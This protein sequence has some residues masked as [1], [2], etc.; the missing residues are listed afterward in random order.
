[1]K[2]KSFAVLG[3]GKYGSSLAAGLY[4]R[5]M[6]VLVC[7]R[8]EERIRDFAGRST[9]AVTCDLADEEALRNLGLENVETA[10]VATAAD[11]SASILSVVVAKEQGVPLVIAKAGSARMAKILKRV[12]ADRVVDPEAEGGQRLATA[13]TSPAILDIFADDENLCILEMTPRKDWIGKSL[14]EID[15][16]RRQ[17]VNI[18]AVRKGKSRWAFPDPAEP[19]SGECVLLVAVEK[20]NLS[21]IQ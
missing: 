19:L 18:I 8:D 9:V 17:G 10:I 15:L 4:D 13:L 14:S 5:G 21:L 16:R 12:G 2:K 3:L 1:M 11:L 20:K 7:D 6:D